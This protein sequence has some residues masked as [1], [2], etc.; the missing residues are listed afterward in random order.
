MR[1]LW[2]S[3]YEWLHGHHPQLV[4]QAKLRLT[5]AYYRVTIAEDMHGFLTKPAWLTN[6]GISFL[7]MPLSLLNPLTTFILGLVGTLTFTIALIPFKAIWFIMFGWLWGTSWLWLKAPILRPLLFLPGVLGAPLCGTYV[8]WMP[9]YG[10]LDYRLSKINACASW[11]LTA[12]LW[13]R[14]LSR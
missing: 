12:A 13:R 5:E 1:H 9:D 6:N 14:M 7:L 10:E 8:G 2:V 11:P 4:V 3:Y